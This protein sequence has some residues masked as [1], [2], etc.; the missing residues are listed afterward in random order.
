MANWGWLVA[1]LPCL[2]AFRIVTLRG[3]VW[4]SESNCGSVVEWEE[5]GEVAWEVAP[6][7]K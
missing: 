2:S 6:D 5:D 3:D 1:W 4:G 7:I